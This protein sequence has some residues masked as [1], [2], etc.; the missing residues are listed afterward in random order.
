MYLQFWAGRCR[1]HS[2]L[3]QRM[4]QRNTG[5]W[6]YTLQLTVVYKFLG[7]NRTYLLG[8]GC[9]G[10]CRV[11]AGW[12]K[13]EVTV[14]LHQKPCREPTTN[15]RFNLQRIFTANQYGNNTTTWH[16][17]SKKFTY[18]LGEQGYCQH[19]C[20][21]P[22]R[23]ALSPNQTYSLVMLLSDNDLWSTQGT[24]WMSHR[25]SLADAKYCRTTIN[26]LMLIT[27]ICTVWWNQ[28][29]KHVPL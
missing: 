18:Q 11:K 28:V 26:V 2:N 14:E 5:T 1:H 20:T 6:F 7:G 29:I 25:R 17:R 10:H 22:W 16:Y 27:M 24:V 9:W 19:L 15:K 13:E 23:N 8:K 12:G 3:K 21:V 4:W